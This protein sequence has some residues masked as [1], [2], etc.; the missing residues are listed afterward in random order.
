MDEFDHG[1]MTFERLGVGMLLLPG[2]PGGDPR[3]KSGEA[4]SPEATEQ[5]G[6]EAHR[7]KGPG[8]QIRLGERR[9][10]PNIYKNES[11]DLR[12]STSYAVGL[13]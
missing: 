2:A 11:T 4:K 13:V 10:K 12:D 6:E 7:A 1:A 3:P 5:N 9:R 8:T